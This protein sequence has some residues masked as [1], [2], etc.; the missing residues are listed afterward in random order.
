[1]GDQA[2]ILM[3]VAENSFVKHTT[4]SNISVYAV[5][6]VQVRSGKIY[7][8]METVNA[9]NLPLTSA[10]WPGKSPTSVETISQGQTVVASSCL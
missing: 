7:I 6:F 9:Q 3:Q 8:T 5:H 1:M 4:L 2:P 10:R